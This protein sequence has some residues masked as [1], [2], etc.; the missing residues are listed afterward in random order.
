MISSLSEAQEILLFRRPRSLFSR[1]SHDENLI[2]V[3]PGKIEKN[4][5]APRLKTDSSAIG[6]G[7]FLVNYI[8][9]RKV[10]PFSC[11]CFSLC[12]CGKHIYIFEGAFF[13]GGEA[14]GNENKV[15]ELEL[16]KRKIRN[17]S[18]FCT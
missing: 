3:L 5:G 8:Q 6:G 10:I 1:T 16:M 17:N 11:I 15:N 12:V 4:L 18:F 2:Q 7:E 14:K 9:T 13:I